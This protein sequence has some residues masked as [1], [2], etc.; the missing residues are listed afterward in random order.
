[1]YNNKKKKIELR[2]ELITVEI[3]ITSFLRRRSSDRSKSF[4]FQ[5]LLGTKVTD[6]NTILDARIHLRG[7]LRGIH[8]RD[9]PRTSNRAIS[10][11]P[12][13]TE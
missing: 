6:T 5:L 13:F 9:Q 2:L 12:G 7:N 11:F 10:M 8:F 1:M 4:R 3:R